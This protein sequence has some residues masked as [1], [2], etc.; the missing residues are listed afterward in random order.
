MNQSTDVITIARDYLERHLRIQL[1]I[2]F[3]DAILKARRN[4]F[5]NG[6]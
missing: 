6:Q 4:R 5:I 2:L 3:R 1:A